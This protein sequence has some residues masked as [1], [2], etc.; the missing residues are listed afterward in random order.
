MEVPRLRARR[1]AARRR[2]G[3]HGRHRQGP[4]GTAEPAAV[5]ARGRRDRVHGE[6]QQPERAAAAGP[7]EAHLRRRRHAHAGRCRAG[8]HRDRAGLRPARQTVAQLL[9]ADRR[10]RRPRLPHLQ[11]RGR[12]PAGQRRRGRFS[13]RVKS[14]DSGHGVAAAADPREGD[15]DV[16]VPE[17]ARLREVRHAAPPVAYGADDLAAGVVRGDGAAVPDG[18]PVRVQRAGVQPALRQRARASHRQLRSEDPPRVRAVEEH[19]R[20]RQPADQEPGPQVGP[21]RGDAVGARGEERERGAP[22]RGRALRRQPPRRRDR[23]HAEE[24]HRPAARRRAL[25]VVPRRPAQR[26]HFAL[27]RDRFRPAAAPRRRG[28]RR[29]RGEGARCAR[30]VDRRALPRDP[31]APGSRGP[32][33]QPH[34]GDL[35]LRPQLLP[36]GPASRRRASQGSGLLPRAAA[37]VLAED[38]LPDVPGAGRARV[39]TFR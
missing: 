1:A 2:A 29:A 39:A 12:H 19:A 27:H 8:Q 28:R 21:A 14:P 23:A 10:A 6:D 25:A 32:C 13:S 31:E 5:R 33:A 35:P 9:V 15:E 17:T 36:R 30:R 11:G 24:T 16:H 34:G 37:Q 3:R 38:G 22:Q 18:V 7:G 4:H 20:P 26:V